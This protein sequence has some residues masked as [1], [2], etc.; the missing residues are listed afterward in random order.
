M[1][2]FKSREE[3][4][5]E[6]TD[7]R[8]KTLNKLRREAELYASLN[9]QQKEYEKLRM[10]KQKYEE[11]HKSKVHTALQVGREAAYILLGPEPKKVKRRRKKVAYA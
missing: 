2:F 1:G 7:K 10:E 9:R 3:K 8:E 11:N 5:R 6:L 4:L